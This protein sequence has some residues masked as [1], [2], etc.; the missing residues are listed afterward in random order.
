MFRT[1]SDDDYDDDDKICTHMV[2]DGEM[3]EKL[4]YNIIKIYEQLCLLMTGCAKTVS[5][6]VIVSGNEG[7]GC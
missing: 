5:V 3:D 4:L 6:S 1:K 7:W 2:A